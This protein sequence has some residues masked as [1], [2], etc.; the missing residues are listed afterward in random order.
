MN[1]RLQIQQEISKCT[2]S[3]VGLKKSLPP[4][5]EEKSSLV[6][7]GYPLAALCGR[8][9]PPRP[10]QVIQSIPFKQHLNFLIELE[11]SIISI[12]S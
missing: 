11:L 6:H 3:L 2:K 10:Q 12:N 5:H 9:T 8:G 4:T 1:M 7:F